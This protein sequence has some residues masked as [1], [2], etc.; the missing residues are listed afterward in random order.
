MV[1]SMQE[2]A[3]QQF[4]TLADRMASIVRTEY[5]QDLSLESI[6]ERLHYTPN[7]LSSIFRKE[8][9]MTFSEYLMNIRLDVARKWLVD[10]NMPIKEIAERL[11]Y[12]NSQN[13]IRTFRK[14]ENLTPGAYRRLRMDS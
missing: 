11:G 2:R 10:T 7:Y 6:S 14:K 3:S 13:F 9:N 5:D 1:D 4:R 12:Q 8:Y